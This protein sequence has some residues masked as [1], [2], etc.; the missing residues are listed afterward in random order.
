MSNDPAAPGDGGLSAGERQQRHLAALGELIPALVHDLNN[1][2]TGISAFAELLEAE[3]TDPDHR[4]SLGMIRTE[5]VKAVRL[6]KDVQAF[7]RASGN[8]SASVDLNAVL[9]ATL[10]LRG[11]LHRGGGMQVH[12]T[13]E[14]ELPHVIG[15]A[16]QL[17]Q[18]IM[19]VM[20]NAEAAVAT[21]EPGAREMRVLTAR[22]GPFVSCTI[23]DS[24]AGM[25]PDVL[26]RIFEPRF[27]THADGGAA[28]LGLAIARQVITA[29]GGT[30]VV[31]STAGRGTRV[32]LRLPAA[33]V[34]VAPLRE[35]AA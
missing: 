23:D 6:L 16:Q 19:H 14:P 28:G 3:V 8:R 20:A 34:A 29:H 32:T 25:S 26:A 17:Q 2:L 24:G 30:I 5:A 12:L 31:D 18:A 22:D 13:L 4:Q 15:D 7:A 27:T 35:S 9:E 33:P 11:Y 1:P 21:R 10:R